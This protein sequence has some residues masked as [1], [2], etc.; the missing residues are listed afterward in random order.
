MLKCLLMLCLMSSCLKSPNTEACGEALALQVAGLEK[1]PHLLVATPGRL[2]DLWDDNEVDLG[3][4]S[5]SP[6]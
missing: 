4:S 1:K 3:V 2:L 6:S 5:V